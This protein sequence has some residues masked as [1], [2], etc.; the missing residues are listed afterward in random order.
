MRGIS[1]PANLYHE[2]E[3]NGTRC[4]GVSVNLTEGRS[5]CQIPDVPRNPGAPE[6]ICHLE[7]FADMKYHWPVRK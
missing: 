1:D 6:E 4:E 5:G 2:D 7:G 3:V